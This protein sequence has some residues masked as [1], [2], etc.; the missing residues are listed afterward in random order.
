MFDMLLNKED[1]FL[2]MESFFIQYSPSKAEAIISAWYNL[3]IE[4]RLNELSAKELESYTYFF[5]QL[6]KLALSAALLG[7]S[8]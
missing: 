7:K 1:A 5:S 4:G 3:K 6:D 8:F 2:L